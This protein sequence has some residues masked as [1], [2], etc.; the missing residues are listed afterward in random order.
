MDS[1]TS[2]VCVVGP[3][4]FLVLSSTG[5]VSAHEGL[6]RAA[7]AVNSTCHVDVCIAGPAGQALLRS[8]PP[9]ARNRWPSMG[10]RS[11]HSPFPKSCRIPKET[12]TNPPRP[13]GRSGRGLVRRRRKRRGHCMR[14]RGIRRGPPESGGQHRPSC[15]R[16]PAVQAGVQRWEPENQAPARPAASAVAQ[17]REAHQPPTTR[18]QQHVKAGCRPSHRTPAPRPSHRTQAPKAS[19]RTQAP[20]PSRP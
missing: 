4:P 3:R 17:E 13:R 11:P 14:V 7:V 10:H 9:H 1:S 12:A 19:H 15:P 16:N 18:H 2:A 5:L 6:L 8:G 20:R